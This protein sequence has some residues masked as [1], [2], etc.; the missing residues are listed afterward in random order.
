[1]V[2]IGFKA[3]THPFNTTEVYEIRDFNTGAIVQPEKFLPSTRPG[4]APMPVCHQH[5]HLQAMMPLP[6]PPRAR[7]FTTLNFQFSMQTTKVM[8]RTSSISTSL[9]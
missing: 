4:L 2:Y 1:V 5:L 8:P 6:L 3:G 9:T 7:A